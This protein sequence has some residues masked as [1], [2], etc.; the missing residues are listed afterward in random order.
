M[1]GGADSEA[2][3][4]ICVDMRRARAFSY[5]TAAR[6]S[7]LPSWV[8]KEYI[9][10]LSFC[11]AMTRRMSAKAS[12]MEIMVEICRFL[13]DM[14]GPRQTSAIRMAAAGASPPTGYRPYSRG[15]SEALV[16]M[17]LRSS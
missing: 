10:F 11:A 16:L 14:L 3:Y 5:M 8:V 2:F 9:S 12:S 15:G 7:T 4:E 1:D 17:L 13:G 6:A